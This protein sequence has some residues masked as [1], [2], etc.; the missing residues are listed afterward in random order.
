M[1][2]NTSFRFL[3]DDE[4]K[5]S[6]SRDYLVSKNVV[7][8]ISNITHKKLFLD[9]FGL[10][11]RIADFNN[12]YDSIGGLST[13][14]YNIG[15]E[16]NP[17]FIHDAL[18]LLKENHGNF[19]KAREGASP[20]II[21]TLNKIYDA[22]NNSN[23]KSWIK[24]YHS[25]DLT[26]E[27]I[28]KCNYLTQKYCRII[29]V[30]EGNNT[31]GI[32]E[33]NGT[34]TAVKRDGVYTLFYNHITPERFDIINNEDN[35]G[36]G[37]HIDYVNPAVIDFCYLNGLNKDLD[38]KEII[39]AGNIV[40]E[41]INQDSNYPDS[42][43]KCMNILLNNYY[44]AANSNYYTIMYLSKLFNIE[45]SEL[46]LAKELL[47]GAISNYIS[48]HKLD[49]SFEENNRPYGNTGVVKTLERPFFG[50]YFVK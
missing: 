15:V 2:K 33:Y 6:F 48:T 27:D 5:Q 43:K 47:I 18:R 17:N 20:A 36:V 11:E 9:E 31:N 14:M 46:I 41:A 29:K 37:G 32:D 1:K 39:E 3:T 23:D 22:F 28:L 26:D 35:K 19:D 40:L 42:I 44:G 24:T 8:Q 38:V 21:K 49:Y 30:F 50:G 45:L 7:E 13:F 25:F 34:L 12:P 4:A 16:L 10:N